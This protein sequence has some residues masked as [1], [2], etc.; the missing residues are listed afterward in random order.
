MSNK[1]EYVSV[2]QAAR[3]MKIS[4][5]AVRELCRNKYLIAEKTGGLWKIS[6]KSIDAW[7]QEP[8]LPPKPFYERHWFITT[9]A[10]VTLL[11]GIAGFIADSG[12]I[13]V[14]AMTF[15]TPTPTLTIVPPS[16]TPTPSSTPTATNTPI[17]PSPLP[18]N[19][20]TTTP[21]NTA[22]P[23]PTVEPEVR[24]LSFRAD[25][26]NYFTD[27]FST[28]TGEWTYL[29]AENSKA[30]LSIIDKLFIDVVTEGSRTWAP[31][32]NNNIKAPDGNYIISIDTIQMEGCDY[33]IVFKG[34]QN[35][36]YYFYLV[37][38]NQA[39]LEHVVPDTSRESNLVVARI[40]LP[41]GLGAISN[42]DV[43]VEGT[44]YS[45]FVNRQL[46]WVYYDENP[47]SGNRIGIE[48][49]VCNNI[50]SANFQFDR[51]QIF[52]SNN[53]LTNDYNYSA[54]FLDQGVQKFNDESYDEAVFYLNLALEGGVMPLADFFYMRG[55]AYYERGNEGDYSLAVED[56]SEALSRQYE[57]LKLTYYFRGLANYELKN[58]DKALQDFEN[59]VER[60]SVSAIRLIGWVYD[61]Q[62][63]YEAAI[64]QYT[65]AYDAGLTSYWV[66]YDRAQST[67]RLCQ[68]SENLADIDEDRLTQSALND[69]EQFLLL[70]EDIEDLEERRN[71]V[72]E[73]IE[74]LTNDGCKAT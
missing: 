23:S 1:N 72:T 40:P 22:T 53:I 2:S 16:L 17:P 67:V 3:Q 50:P 60:G 62:Q 9:V 6:T 59:S 10:I 61:R 32:T 56:L 5:R 39:A 69:Y 45:L 71:D 66:F 30:S 24:L 19:T 12:L 70:S 48:V 18:S 74:N 8:S 34:T 36:E 14:I 44:Y 13:Q 29:G 28:D 52:S 38:R 41:E 73:I 15:A 43:L 4:E 33:G 58:Y 54:I 7:L 68:S 11:G 42:I 65:K 26:Q 57:D 25:W 63:N 27:E 46:I 64:E 20:P 21:T 37:G 31:F 55:R 49:M 35:D 47:L 51:F